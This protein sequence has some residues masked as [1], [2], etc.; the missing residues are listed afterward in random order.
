M[1][2]KKID[3]MCFVYPKGVVVVDVTVL[4]TKVLVVV[5][6]LVLEPLVTIILY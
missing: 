3:D 2:R 4:A 5:F 1:I 6:A